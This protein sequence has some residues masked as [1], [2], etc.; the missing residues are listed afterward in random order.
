MKPI[1]VPA[2]AQKSSVVVTTLNDINDRGDIV[3][4]VYGLSAQDFSALK[5]IDAVLWRCAFS[6]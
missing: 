1:A 6:S 2:A 4:N 5:R 3:G